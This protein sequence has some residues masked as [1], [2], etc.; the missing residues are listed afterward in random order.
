MNQSLD[1]KDHAT[2]RLTPLLHPPSWALTLAFA[3]VYLCWGTTY[4][5]IRV[6]VEAFPPALFG[7]IRVG[8]AGLLLLIFLAWRG[9][10]VQLPL[11]DLLEAA[12]IGA[13]FF[14]GGNYLI[15]VGEKSVAS[16]IASLLV[17]TTPLWMALIEA[18]WPGGERLAV[19]GWIGI[20]AGLCGAAV[21][22]LENPAD[23]VR[24]FGPLLCLGSAFL[25]AFGSVMMRRLRMRTGLATAAYQ[26]FI[27]GWGLTLLGL[28]RG[29]A[30]ELTP[31]QFTPVAIYAFFHLLVFG[32]LAG[33]VAYIW[34]LGHV[35]STQAGTYAY[36]NP[37]VAVLIG[38]L[39]AGE[40]VTV[41]IVTGMVI[42]LTGVYL[43]RTGGR[44]G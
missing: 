14:M 6:G 1:K 36:V 28:A 39:L 4:L 26:M 41:A 7:G 10:Q 13:I 12:L 9:D 40:S 22:K 21:L 33:F 31:D 30:S 17:T 42:I 15:T 5:A 2:Q 16:G 37:V 19:R 25:W 38:W 23:L 20:L 24:D 8:L 3:L 29:E 44:R 27:G 43:V 18:L 11:R 34:L 32:S 35:T